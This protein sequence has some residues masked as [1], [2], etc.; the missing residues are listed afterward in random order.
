MLKYIQKLGN[1]AVHSS[2]PISR[3]QSVL[4][5]RNL[6]EFIS[7]IDYCYSDELHESAFNESL[8]GD[9]EQE[10]K[11]R[12]ELI[13]LHEKLGS[14]DRKLEEVIKENEELRKENREKE[15]ETNKIETT[16]LMK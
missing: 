6:Y 11:T 2:T 14:K 1:K 16:I 15:K 8:L 10:K 12:K 3:E 7:W 4:A 9:S 13:E 5:L